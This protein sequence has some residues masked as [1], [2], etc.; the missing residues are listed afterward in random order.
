MS[1]RRKLGDGGGAGPTTRS[2]FDLCDLVCLDDIPLDE[3]TIYADAD[4]SRPML[5]TASDLCIGRSS[6]MRSASSISTATGHSLSPIPT[7]F[8]RPSSPVL[9]AKQQYHQKHQDYELFLQQ[10]LRGMNHHPDEPPSA[11]RLQPKSKT[12]KG[13]ICLFP[14]CD[15]SFD[16]Q[17]E[18]DDHVRRSHPYNCKW[19][20]CEGTASFRTHEAL[21]LHVNGVHLGIPGAGYKAKVEE[22]C[23]KPAEVVEWTLEPARDNEDAPRASPGASPQMEITRATYREL[24]FVE[25]SKRDCR[26]RLQN[27][28]DKK[29]DRSRR[30]L[31]VEYAPFPLVFEHAVLPFLKA[32]LPRWTTPAHSVL[33]IRGKTPTSKRICITTRVSISRPRRVVICRHVMDL[34]PNK[35][36]NSVS[37]VFAV[38][39][40]QRIAT[41]ARGLGVNHPD[42]ICAPRNP[43]SFEVPC[44]GDS[45]GIRASAVFE[46][47]T[48][49]LGPCLDI[50]GVSFWLC[51]FH[52]FEEAYRAHGTNVKV[53][54]PSPQDRVKC[55]KDA[56]DALS[57]SH[58]YK[59]GDLS[60]TSGLNLKTTRLSHDRFW[61]DN[62]MDPP[63]VVTDWALLRAKTTSDQA[64]LL[65]RFPCESNPLFKQ[66]IVNSTS[67]V[68]PGGVV[69]S[70]GRTS[71]YQ[72][73]QVCDIPAYVSGDENGTGKATREWF[74]EEPWASDDEE[75]WIRGGIGVEGDSGAAVV[76][77]EEG[78]LVGQ[79]WGRNRY[80]GPG[81]RITYF[82]P[83]ADILDDI[84]EKCGQDDRP[85]LPQV[86]DDADCIP[87]YPHCR[88]CY[89][90][91]MYLES[92]RSS[93]VSLQS[94]IMGKGD[95]DQELAS[96]EAASELATPR[97]DA[98]VRGTGIEEVGAS[99]DQ[100]LPP[101]VL[102]YSVGTPATAP[103][104]PDI[105]SPY[106]QMIDLDDHGNQSPTI[107]RKR[108]QT[109]PKSS[110][111]GATVPPKRVRV[112]E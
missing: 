87:T 12:S 13:Y 51:N 80:W 10:A 58:D 41:W 19:T 31:S 97:D 46:E 38:G 17:A 77:A 20:G 66:P 2:G 101:A 35:F 108:A 76:D 45:I 43:F 44:M 11:K 52:P 28:L 8:S 95:C 79:L 81:P 98:H 96:I 55:I 63:H 92:R 78:S 21:V 49:T 88:Q 18:L 36:R 109:P 61:A 40:T 111:N 60:V 90:L 42:D 24:E 32:H 30:P 6:S 14:S 5:V 1:K 100:R 99:F 7:E 16:R 9:Q 89:D 106:A 104:T 48:A 72:K 65:R 112:R 102:Y 103:D 56:H 23:T 69:L 57:P 71:G 15:G 91:R 54:H 34:L 110:S 53:E 26:S 73:G 4:C 93:R 39:N 84:Q 29:V 85:K 86:R 50:D 59:L 47:S 33:V 83:I 82:T 105:R 107:T 62:F 64:N 3:T 75:A 70:S 22:T 27:A 37:L 67:A 94:M 74:I 68:V 25:A